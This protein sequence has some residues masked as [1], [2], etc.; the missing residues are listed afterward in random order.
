MERRDFDKSVETY[1]DAIDID[2]LFDCVDF[3]SNLTLDEARALQDAKH[4]KLYLKCDIMQL[5]VIPI[6]DG[7]L[8]YNRQDVGIEPSERKPIILYID[9]NGGEVEEGFELIDVIQSSK[10]PVYTV[11]MGY[12]YSMGFLVGLAGHKR[13]ATKNARYLMHDGSS[14]IYGSTTKVRD[15]TEFINA[16]ERRIKEYIL[17]RS[18]LT[19]EEYDAKLRVEWYMF[20]DEAKE[21]GFT[22]YII[23]VDC[24]IDAII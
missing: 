18:K 7:I 13:F 22:D 19:S 4:R 6:I 2:D 3:L 1:I 23:G 5:S 10:T 17:S 24:D 8:E 21:H 12:Q 15:Q 11:N 9:S 16:S 14:F 20:A